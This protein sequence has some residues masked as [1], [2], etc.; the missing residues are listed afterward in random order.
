M[1][2]RMKSIICR[3]KEDKY[4]LIKFVI[5]LVLAGYGMI[6][7][8]MQWNSIWWIV[9]AIIVFSLMNCSAVMAKLKINVKNILF[10]LFCLLYS[11]ILIFGYHIKVTNIDG[12]LYQDN[13]MLSYGLNDIAAFIFLIFVNAL[14][15]CAISVAIEWM[16]KKLDLKSRA[17]VSKKKLWLKV[18]VGLLICWIP[19]LLIYY[20]GYVFGDSMNSIYQAE[21]LIQWN[22]HHPIVYTAFIKI[23]LE[24]GKKIGDITFGCAIYTVLQ[25][26]YLAVCF[27]YLIN[28]MY[29]KGIPKIWRCVSFALFGIVPFYAEMSIAMWKDPIFSASLAVWTVMLIDFIR[30]KDEEKQTPLFWLKHVFFMCVICFF[31]NN[32]MY[33]LAATEVILLLVLLKKRKLPIC[34]ALKKMF[35]SIAAIILCVFVI[36]GPIYSRLGLQGESVESYGIFLNQMARV[37]VTDGNMNEEETAFMDQLLPIEKY[38]E[39]YHPCQIDSLKWDPDFDNEFLEQHKSEFIHAWL[40]M[41]KKNF[42]CYV[43]SWGF[44]TYGYWAV[45]HL[46]FNQDNYNIARGNRNYLYENES[47]GIE[48]HSLLQNIP[49]HFEKVFKEHDAFVAMAWIN[50]LVVGLAFYVMIKKKGEWLLVLA[51]SLGNI[52]TLLIASP[53]A[54]WQRYGLAEYYLLPVY[55]V[56]PFL[57]FEK[58][59]DKMT[60]SDKV[61]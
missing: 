43:E 14:F 46:E 20:P 56:L 22:N 17:H 53:Y 61:E 52:A 57:L 7:G 12:G 37:V 60:K 32:G 27:G 42:K 54:Y 18:T 34:K 50:V 2:N 23:C 49:V 59:S 11:A 8:G 30:N 38:K 13:Y 6:Y 28:W 19:Y 35:V 21:H 41:M 36:T 39:V 3:L 51:P 40:S 25:M 5:S 48:P 1:G 58:K 10:V 9:L 45:N 33:I 16:N 47:C 31:R 29:E 4:F 15:L 44:M 26:L 24:A 55:L